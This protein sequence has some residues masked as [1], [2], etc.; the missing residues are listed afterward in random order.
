MKDKTKK[1]VKSI[2]AGVLA[3]VGVFGLT[4]CSNAKD[5]LNDALQQIEQ[6]KAQVNMSNADEMIEYSFAKLKLNKNAVLNNLTINF[7]ISG[8]EEESSIV[9]CYKS[10]DAMVMWSKDLKDNSL[11]IHYTEDG[12]SYWYR[13]GQNARTSITE[14]AYEAILDHISLDMFQIVE[15]DVVKVEVLPNGNYKI[16]TLF[17]DEDNNI[18]EI[19]YEITK[20]NDLV[21]WELTMSYGGDSVVCKVSLS[22]GVNVEEVESLLAEAKAASIRG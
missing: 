15:E 21:C 9:Q 2:G 10:E 14:T 3:C 18:G 19:A 1:I 6:L 13:P 11:Y 4:G 7:E 20:D 16:L 12:E 22:V 17:K 5:Q 8:S